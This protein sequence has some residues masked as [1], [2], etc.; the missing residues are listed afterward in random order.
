M[1]EATLEYEL[2]QYEGRTYFLVGRATPGFDDPASF[3]AIVAYNDPSTGDSVQVARIDTAHGET[4]FDRLYRR[5]QPSDPV[6]CSFWG[7]NRDA[8]V[9]LADIRPR[10]RAE[11][12]IGAVSISRW[13]NQ[14][15]NRGQLETN[16]VVSADL[17]LLTLR[18]PNST[19][20]NRSTQ[21]GGMKGRGRVAEPRR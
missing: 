2:G 13:A 4:H 19:C 8:G 6:N 18:A 12:V 5:G 16:A 15:V 20:P 9:K 17:F 7:G 1:A 21:P 14:S 11:G 10:L 3:A